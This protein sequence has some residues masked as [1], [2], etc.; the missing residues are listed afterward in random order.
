[1]PL[2]EG[3]KPK[4]ISARHL[5]ES[6]KLGGNTYEATVL[7]ETGGTAA[8]TMPLSARYAYSTNV[9]DLTTP[10][11]PD[12]TSL[13][14]GDVVLLPLQSTASENGLYVVNGSGELERSAQPLTPLA[15]INVAEGTKWAETQFK[16]TNNVNF[17]VGTD[18]ITIKPNGLQKAG[19]AGSYNAGRLNISAGTGISLSPSGID[20]FSNQVQISN[21]GV[22]SLT[23]ETGGIGVS[24]G[25]G[26]VTVTNLG[27][28]KITADSTD[29]TG[30]VSLTSPDASITINASGSTI[31][32]TTTSGGG[33]SVDIQ[34]FAAS[35]TWTK[36]AG[37]HYVIVIAI[38]AGGGG[39][40]GARGA[41]GN[42]HSGGGGGATGQTIIAEFISSDCGATE[43]VTI[44]GG[45]NGGAAKSANGAGNDGNDG[46]TTSFG[47]L[48]TALGGNKGL[49]GIIS[50]VT[51]ANGGATVQCYN[52]FS[53]RTSSQGGASAS[54]ALYASN[55][56][57]IVLMSSA[58]GG[59]GTI[60]SSGTLRNPATGGNVLSASGST[61]CAAGSA[62][63]TAGA[64]GGNGNSSNTYLVSSGGGGGA[65]GD[66]GGTVAGGTGGNGGAQYGGGGGGG[67]SSV[68][69]ANSGGGGNGADGFLRVITYCG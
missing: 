32:L 59:G 60:S 62:T 68:T 40:S 46:G 58:G 53:N 52:R 9:S 20:S 7:P 47:S 21:S 64:N 49:G 44:G 23:G 61:I 8:A 12:G 17:V 4:S 2:N 50:G 51:Q 38:G 39:G 24:A 63:I 6:L 13:V 42:N 36:P 22:T 54:N 18:D 65:G 55:V 14:T 28:K 26:A 66:S 57:D 29:F 16:I 27:V 15:V 45:G 1:M 41:A 31:E 30:N 69:G 10:A 25:T 35:G 19:I 37:A 67:G 34:D 3:I 33:G 5:T 56:A 48:L 11:T 43:T